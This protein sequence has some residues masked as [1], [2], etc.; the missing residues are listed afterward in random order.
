MPLFAYFVGIKINFDGKIINQ[1]N[2]SIWMLAK[3]IFFHIMRSIPTQLTK[4]S[5]LHNGEDVE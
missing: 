3:I 4:R 2:Y 5:S 1:L